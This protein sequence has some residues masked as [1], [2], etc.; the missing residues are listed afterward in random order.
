MKRLIAFLETQGYSHVDAVNA[1]LDARLR[2]I[3]GAD[4]DVVLQELKV[5]SEYID[6]LM[7]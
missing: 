1:V 6:A 5:G 7:A 2:V 4:P 3:D